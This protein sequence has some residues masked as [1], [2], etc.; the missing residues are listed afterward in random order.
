MPTPATFAYSTPAPIT[1]PTPAPIP[2]TPGAPPSSAPPPSRRR[3][4]VAVEVGNTLRRDSP[5]PPKGDLEKEVPVSESDDDDEGS[6]GLEVS[7]SLDTQQWLPQHSE[8]E[9]ESP[10][11]WRRLVA[12]DATNSEYWDRLVEAYELQFNKVAIGLLP[13]GN[14]DGN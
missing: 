5:S 13:S 4:E 12:K 11:H 8:P 10:V 2:F 3:D 9:H 7:W 14:R 6:Q 1:Y